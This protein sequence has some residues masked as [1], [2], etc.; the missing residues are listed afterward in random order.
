MITLPSL[1][2]ANLIERDKNGVVD[3]SQSVAA[4]LQSPEMTDVIEYHAK[5]YAPSRHGN[6]NTFAGSN[7][8][9]FLSGWMDAVKEARTSDDAWKD[10]I[11]RAM[12]NPSEGYIVE[13]IDQAMDYVDTEIRGDDFNEPLFDVFF[14]ALADAQLSEDDRQDDDMLE[15]LRD[16]ALNQMANLVNDGAWTSS[17]DFG[18]RELLEDN[19]DKLDFLGASH[20]KIEWTIFLNMKPD[21]TLDNTFVMQDMIFDAGHPNAERMMRDFLG[22]VNMP[23][24]D[25][26]NAIGENEFTDKSLAMFQSIK[27]PLPGEPSLMAASSV[28]EVLTNA[29]YGG[30]AVI[31]GFASAFDMM[32]CDPRQSM[33]INGNIQIGIHDSIN[34]VGHILSMNGGN[35]NI[36][37]PSGFMLEHAVG[38]CGRYSIND[39]YDFVKGAVS[40]ELTQEHE[41]VS[42]HSS[43]TEF[44]M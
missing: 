21:E 32:R 8:D 24:Q 41:P 28:A 29:S 43:K 23:G 2:T 36:L 3:I 37:L 1:N 40:I 22:F 10:I 19:T 15:S 17:E 13:V 5:H 35:T 27:A 20:D 39:V 31:F 42:A 38:E 4:F 25:V 44:S 9:S 6:N 12:E 33:S 26:I 30:H 14:E 11:E 7:P 18:F 16:E 34:G